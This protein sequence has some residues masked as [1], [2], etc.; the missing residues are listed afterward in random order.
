MLHSQ[1]ITNKCAAIC[2]NKQI[3][4]KKNTIYI[5]GL[6]LVEGHFSGIGQYVLGILQG[7]DTIIEMRKLT[8][9][10]VPVVC[11][12]I[13]RDTVPRFN[14]FGFKHIQ[15]KTVPFSFRVMSALWHRRKMPPLDLFCGKGLYVFTRFVDMPLLFS[16]SCV[17]IYDLSYE[18]FKQYS[19][20]KNALFLSN[21]VRKSIAK[22]ER[23]ITISESAKREIIEFYKYDPSKIVVAY[24]AADQRYFYKRSLDEIKAVKNKYGIKGEYIIA[25]SNLE[26]RKN[27]DG[28]VE[29]YCSL[30]KA[31]TDKIGLLLVGVNGWKIEKLFDKIV[32]R[33]GEGFNIMRPSHYVSDEDKPAIISGAKM[34]V[35]PSHYEGFGMPPLE[36]LACGVPVITANNSS[37]PEVVGR[38]GDTIDSNDT[39]GLTEAIKSNLEDWEKLAVKLRTAG[40]DQATKFSWGKS[41]ETILDMAKDINK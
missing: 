11:V 17:I 26:P 16:K 7:L 8:G 24:P 23:I 31:T 3:I 37:L 13:P 27:L 39:E 34:L 30:P 35:Y 4:V 18:L 36:A 29:A 14:S 12:V 22:S 10:N 32:N 5:E 2:Y 6:A 25:L 28:L 19:D 41:A 38:V 40:P 21:G 9:E 1:S 33:V 20:E 15:Y